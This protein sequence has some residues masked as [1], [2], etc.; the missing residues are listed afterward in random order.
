MRPHLTLS[1]GVRYE[2]T[3]T[4]SEPAGRLASL[5]ALNS[6]TLHVG[7][8]YYN[9]PSLRNVA[10]RVGVAWDPYGMARRPSARRMA[11]TTR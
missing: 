6:G 7:G 4:V 9:N 3:S 11:F 1:L 10:P 2:P 8:A 5:T